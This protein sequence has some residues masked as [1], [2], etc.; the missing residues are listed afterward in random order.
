MLR[1]SPGPSEE[2][3]VYRRSECGALHLG[4]GRD[5]LEA[6]DEA[7]VPGQGMT[8]TSVGD[9]RAYDLHVLDVD[10]RFPEQRHIGLLGCADGAVYGA[11]GFCFRE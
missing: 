4:V 11:V 9:D 7:R 8:S 1:H 3:A 6:G 5:D 2:L 10:R